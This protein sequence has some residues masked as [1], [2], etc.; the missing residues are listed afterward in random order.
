MENIRFDGIDASYNGTHS[1]IAIDKLS[2]N[3]FYARL[4]LSEKGNLN[5]STIFS[6]PA[7][8][9]AVSSLPDTSDIAKSTGLQNS[10][11][12]VEIKIKQTVFNGGN[13]NFQ[14]ILSNQTTGRI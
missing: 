4:I 2:L 11:A 14:I 5:L 7:S 9:I 3:N 6:K 1:K 13:I 12:D 10:P 8:A